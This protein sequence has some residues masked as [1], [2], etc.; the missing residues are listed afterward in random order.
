[1]PSPT[2]LGKQSFLPT[3]A[4]KRKRDAYASLFL[5]AH[6][7]QVRPAKNLEL[8]SHS[9]LMTEIYQYSRQCVSRI[10]YR[11]GTN[12]YMIEFYV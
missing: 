9:F 6:R 2:S 11:L 10:D 12:A 3:L 4:R 5:F 8:S 1:M 7:T